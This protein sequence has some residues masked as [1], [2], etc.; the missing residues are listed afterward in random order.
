MSN[1]LRL[2]LSLP[3]QLVINISVIITLIYVSVTSSAL[4]YTTMKYGHEKLRLI[5]E[6]VSK[7]TGSSLCLPN[8]IGPA[9]LPDVVMGRLYYSGPDSVISGD[10]V[11]HPVSAQRLA[12]AW[13]P[14]CALIPHGHLPREGRTGGTQRQVP[15]LLA[16]LWDMPYFG[17]F[18]GRDSHGA[19]IEPTRAQRASGGGV[20]VRASHSG[21]PWGSAGSVESLCPVTTV[22]SIWIE[23]VRRPGGSGCEPLT[24]SRWVL[25]SSSIVCG[26]GRNHSLKLC[27]P[28]RLNLIPPFLWKENSHQ[29]FFRFTHLFP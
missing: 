7:I 11:I 17:Q 25:E 9:C 14:V 10:E 4:C 22:A 16:V 19:L 28:S 26:A 27:H 6:Q 21:A 2:W 15:A 24:S 1:T 8:G 29:S 12:L 13:F 23:I 20:E 18:L 5:M 3:I